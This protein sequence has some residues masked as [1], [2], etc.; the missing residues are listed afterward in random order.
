MRDLE[1]TGTATASMAVCRSTVG[2]SLARLQPVIHDWLAEVS[3]AINSHQQGEQP[4][5]MTTHNLAGAWVASANRM[6]WCAE[7]LSTGDG[8][9]AWDMV[10]EEPHGGRKFAVWAVGLIPSMTDKDDALLL[11][12]KGLAHAKASAAELSLG[13]GL[14]R[15]V[16]A[17]VSPYVRS[18]KGQDYELAGL[19]DAW[20]AQFPFRSEQSDATAEACVMLRTDPPR[21]A[22]DLIFPGV[23]LNAELVAP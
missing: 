8:A 23:C 11:I 13:Q 22:A 20:L 16:L 15:L 12:E 5:W 9:P 18:G 7:L 3:A 14:E 21:N 19:V 2:P 17:F 1:R 4:W 6:G 10:L